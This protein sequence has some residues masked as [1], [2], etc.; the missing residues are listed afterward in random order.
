[1]SGTLRDIFNEF[2]CAKVRTGQK[3]DNN[4]REID[5]CIK[6]HESRGQLN[7]KY[8][9]CLEYL[10]KRKECLSDYALQESY[11]ILKHFSRW[12]HLIDKKN[13]ELP[14]RKRR[15]NG[16][17]VPQILEADQ[18]CQ[19][20]KRMRETCVH[21]PLSADTYS[22]LIG[23]LFV[24]GMRVSEALIN[25]SDEDV[26]LEDN[27]IYVREDKVQRDRYIPISNSTSLM[28]SKYRSRR[29]KR[30]PD[31]RDRF[32]LIHNG[33]PN[34]PHGFRSMFVKVT[35]ELGLRS[36]DKQS[37]SVT[38]AVPHDLRHSYATHTLSRFHREG[39]DIDEEIPKLSIVLGHESIRRT[40]WYIESVP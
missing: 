24:T 21:F 15:L 3:S 37:K 27:Y 20:I 32:F 33:A 26:N 17:K 22:T 28:L 25:L 38:N 9:S 14:R 11:H 36:S 19:I 5:R 13:E 7:L 12:A 35:E 6:H 30:F 8:S 29:E 23:L 31:R 34:T 10:E 1:M 18:V 16:R 39:L 2:R 4:F 40:Y